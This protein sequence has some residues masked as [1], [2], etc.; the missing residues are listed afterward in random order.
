MS[1]VICI[2]LMPGIIAQNPLWML[3]KSFWMTKWPFVSS[4]SSVGASRV[5]SWAFTI[6]LRPMMSPSSPAIHLY[7]SWMPLP[8][9]C[10]CHTSSFC[11]SSILALCVH[12]VENSVGMWQIEGQRKASSVVS[13]S[14]EGLWNQT[15]VASLLPYHALCS[16]K[17]RSCNFFTWK[18]RSGYMFRE[19]WED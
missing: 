5:M 17:V 15:R 11:Y 3:N 12:C 16:L 18:W 8:L 4:L 1:L 13:D 6:N 2:S 10:A 7:E 19:L 14:E 9:P